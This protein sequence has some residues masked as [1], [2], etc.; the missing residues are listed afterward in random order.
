MEY[1]LHQYSMKGNRYERLVSLTRLLTH[2]T[3]EEIRSCT[4]CCP[5]ES[6]RVPVSPCFP[7]GFPEATSPMRH[8]A[9]RG[10]IK[11]V[12][13]CKRDGVVTL[14]A[15]AAAR[16]EDYVPERKAPKSSGLITLFRR[17][18]AKELQGVAGQNPSGGRQRPDTQVNGSQNTDKRGAKYKTRST[19]DLAQI[20]AL[21][22]NPMVDRGHV[23]TIEKAMKGSL[24]ECFRDVAQINF[25]DPVTYTNIRIYFGQVTSY[26]AFR[27]SILV[28]CINNSTSDTPITF[29]VN[30]ETSPAIR[31]AHL[32]EQLAAARQTR[33]PIF[34]LGSFVLTDSKSYPRWVCGVA[35]VNE[36]YVSTHTHPPQN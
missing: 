2:A 8:F 29:A 32:L 10:K 21:Y 30:I 3:Q 4:Y 23:I 27:E 11:H 36:V 26:R 17:A 15:K 12:A 31:V 24:N 6:C 16:G 1:A 25:K 35:N 22:E 5:N 18:T 20:V 14:Q 28:Y 13:N 33:R 9:A 7:K 19:Y 34:A